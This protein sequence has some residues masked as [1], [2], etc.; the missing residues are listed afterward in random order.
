MKPA[1]KHIHN[2]AHLNSRNPI[3]KRWNEKDSYTTQPKKD[4]TEDELKTK[5]PNTQIKSKIGR[6]VGRSSHIKRN[7]AGGCIWA[8]DRLSFQFL[9]IRTRVLLLKFSD[10]NDKWKAEAQM[11]T[12]SP[13]TSQRC[14]LILQHCLAIQ[15]SK[16]GHTPEDFWMYDSGYMIF[17]VRFFK[18]FFNC[19]ISYVSSVVYTECCF[20][21]AGKNVIY[22]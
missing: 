2:I 6:L 20:G 14:R 4:R 5:K 18:M 19:S 12:K 11:G 7:L 8:K 10:S 9:V 17:Q 1:W 21:I 3:R 16:P 15:L 13:G 22:T